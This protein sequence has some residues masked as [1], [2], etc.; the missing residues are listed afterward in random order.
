MLTERLEVR[1]PV[2]SDRARFVE[3]FCDPDFMVFSGEPC[4]VEHANTRFDGMLANC[5]ELQFAKQPVVERSTGAVVGYCGVAPLS[6]RGNGG[7]SSGIDSSPRRGD[8]GTRR[9]R[10]ARCSR[11]RPRRSGASCWR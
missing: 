3:L 8:G 4:T 5:A 6:S 7:W 11:W 10:D 1:P 9:K 2:E